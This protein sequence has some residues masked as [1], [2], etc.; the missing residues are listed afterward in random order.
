MSPY[1][2]L[3]GSKPLTLVTPH[4][5]SG[6]T[7]TVEEF[8]HEREALNHLLQEAIAQAQ[9]RYKHNADKD[10]SEREFRVGEWVYLELQSYRQL[11]TTIR[12]NHKLVHKYFGPYKVMARIG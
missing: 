10:R 5:I 6:V 9:H 3:Y 11:S 8:F 1:E 7:T 2:A 12:R 4:A